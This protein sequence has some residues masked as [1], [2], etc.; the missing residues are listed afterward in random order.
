MVSIGKGTSGDA[1]GDRGRLSRP[2]VY[3]VQTLRIF[4]RESW[5]DFIYGV[6]ELTKI[7]SPLTV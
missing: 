1:K 7:E 2:A 3:E 4:R 6:K 5:G